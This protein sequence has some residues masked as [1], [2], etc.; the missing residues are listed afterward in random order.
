MTPF[1]QP[2]QERLKQKGIESFTAVKGWTF[3]PLD[4]LDVSYRL[5]NDNDEVIGYAEVI[6]LVRPIRMAYPL[7]FRIDK[8]VKLIDKRLNPFL[9]W[10]CEDGIMYAKAADVTGIFRFKS[11]MFHGYLDKQSAIKYIRYK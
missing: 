5:F 4:P 7:P 10:S 3:R 9:V 6:P 8:L 1:N 2:E 11:T